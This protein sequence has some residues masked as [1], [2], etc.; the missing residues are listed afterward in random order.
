MQNVAFVYVGLLC[1]LAATGKIL[2]HDHFNTLKISSSAVLDAT[3]EHVIIIRH[4]EALID[5]FRPRPIVSS[6]VFQV[7]FVHLVYNSAF[8]CILLLFAG[9][10]SS[11]GVA[12]R[13]VLDGPGIESR[14]GRDFPHLS[15]PPWGPPSLLYNGYRVFPGSK[16]AGTWRRPPTPI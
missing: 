12:I 11:V 3:K 5:L 7:V 9:R 15:R 8:I 10:D 16:E 13:Y 14:W 2:Y 6:N 1:C 4:G